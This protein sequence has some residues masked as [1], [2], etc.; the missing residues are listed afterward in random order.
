MLT[1]TGAYKL[2]EI[3]THY[4]AV[5][6]QRG[7]RIHC[8]VFKVS[9]YIKRYMGNKLVSLKFLTQLIRK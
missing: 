6:D 2:E 7:S 4:R 9:V 5:G 3:F 1:W 8:P